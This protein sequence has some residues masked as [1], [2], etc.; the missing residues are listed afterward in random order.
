MN[1][2]SGITSLP[3]DLRTLALGHRCVNRCD[4][5]VYDLGKIEA[6][7]RWLDAHSKLRRSILVLDDSPSALL[8][9]VDVL[10]P[11]EL[12]IHAVTLDPGQTVRAALIAQGAATVHAVDDPLDAVDVWEETRSAVVVTDVHLGGHTTGMD[13]IGAVRD[14]GVRCVLITSCDPEDRASVE[15]VA[16]RV[17]AEG[18]VRTTSP[19]WETRLRRDVAALVDAAAPPPVE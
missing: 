4:Q 13:V 6:A 17:H 10:A 8:A 16:R 5:I 7:L 3:A 19:E 2:Q 15:R 11:L 18:I 14:R 1:D 12:P 9:L